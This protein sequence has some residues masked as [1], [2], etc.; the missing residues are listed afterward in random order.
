MPIEDGR[1]K[2]TLASIKSI[3]NRGLRHVQTSLPPGRPGQL[4]CRRPRPTSS[5]TANPPS[6]WATRA[7]TAR[8]AVPIPGYALKAAPGSVSTASRWCALAM[9]HSTAAA[10][11][12][13]CRPVETCLRNKTSRTIP[14]CALPTSRQYRSFHHLHQWR[15]RLCRVCPARSGDCQQAV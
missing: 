5:S 11:A 3:S 8:V 13:W 2:D 1:P 10:W 6:V 4:S 15:L 9:Q 12:K 7:C 14:Q